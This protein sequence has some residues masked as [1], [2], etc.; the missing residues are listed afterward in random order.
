MLPKGSI[1]FYLRVDPIRIKVIK[2]RKRQ[3]QTALIFQFFLI[4]QILITRILSVLQYL[5]MCILFGLK[6][7]HAPSSSVDF[8]L[9]SICIVV[10]L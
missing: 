10:V 5:I 7:Y 3:N 6:S 8:I 9:N 2:I 4:C 1:F